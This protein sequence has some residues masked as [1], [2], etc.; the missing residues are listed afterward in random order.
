VELGENGQDGGVERS[1]DDD[2]GFEL[3][4]EEEDEDAV[5]FDNPYFAE[6]AK[7]REPEKDRED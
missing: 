7:V 2:E 5:Y 1:D 6:E 4:L 3:A